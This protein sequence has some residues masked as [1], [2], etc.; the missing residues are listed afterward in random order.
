MARSF[1]ALSL[2]LGAAASV[3]AFDLGFSATGVASLDTPNAFW[4]DIE[5][6]VEHET[7]GFGFV[8]DMSAQGDGTYG[9]ILGDYYG[10]LS[11]LIDRGG[12]TYDNGPFS[13][14]VGK[15]ALEDEVDSPYS[16]FLSGRKN[17]ALTGSLR[18][19]DERFFFSDR[20]IALNYD[21][22]N[23]ADPAAPTR[24][25]PWP[26]RSA[27]LKTYGVKLGALRLGLQDL[28]IFT[29]K[30]YGERMR[31]P[32]FEP[33]Y[34]LNP[35]PSF[36]IQ[37]AATNMDSPWKRDGGLNDNSIIGLFADWRGDGLAFDVQLLVDDINMNRILKPD[38][39]QNPD[40]IAW[41]L[42]CAFETDAGAFRIDHAGATKHT[43]AP[44]GYGSIDNLE[45]GYTFYPDTVFSLDGESSPIRP[46]DNYVGYL[47]GENNLA[48][49]GS[50]AR[51]FGALAVDAAAEFTLS[52]SKSP[53][54]PWHAY[55][56]WSEGGE[57][58]K[59]LDD[60][61]LEK[62]FLV[63]GRAEWKL[64]GLALFAEGSA[65]Y[66][67]NKLA[68]TEVPAAVVVASDPR[69]N[70]IPLF[71]P[72]SESGPAGSLAVG[73]SYTLRY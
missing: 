56:T 19:E 60:A 3:A 72:S 42:G 66:V 35:A 13:L 58:T 9:A 2:A 46:E 30:F 65:G 20:W 12:L 47:H 14:A 43:F 8:W 37:Y 55:T 27:V 4:P 44:S 34:F 15:L 26:D 23:D 41:A 24:T 6:S 16:L 54:N 31:G 53:A 10:G 32:L 71:V 5:L 68:L 45:Y 59:F 50:W 18:F 51:T 1:L 11:V 29:D 67:W 36:F 69:G 17:A 39:F 64:G 48:F 57:G 73:A 33:E 25:S 62:K 70:G 21:S 28:A 61:V 38:S 63:T 49:R 7:S 40:K 52:G 22:V